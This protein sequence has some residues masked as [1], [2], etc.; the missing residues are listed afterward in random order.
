LKIEQS[1]RASLKLLTGAAAL[2]D[3][4][5]TALI[6]GPLATKALEERTTQS[7]DILAL[8]RNIQIGEDT[9]KNQQEQLAELRLIVTGLDKNTEAVVKVKDSLRAPVG[10]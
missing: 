10:I 4:Q 9:L 6:Q 5:Q 1:I 3:L 8:E 2:S 7:P